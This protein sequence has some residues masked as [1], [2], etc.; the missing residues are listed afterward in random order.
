MV[1][2][3]Y[4]SEIFWTTDDQRRVA[5]DTISDVDAAGI[6]PGKVVTAV[7]Q[8]GVFWEAEACDQDYLERYP[9]GNVLPR[10]V[11][12]AAGRKTAA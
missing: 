11:L 12:E 6:W 1:G 9:D 5:Q 4:R 10:L 3:G 7:C 2:S 8:A